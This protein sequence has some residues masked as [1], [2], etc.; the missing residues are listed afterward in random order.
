MFVY[1][2]SQRRVDESTPQN[3]YTYTQLPQ[4]PL[5]IFL[6]ICQ[7]RLAPYLSQRVTLRNGVKQWQIQIAKL[8][9]EMI[10][11]QY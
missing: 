6:S 7:M 8:V 10:V 4:F 11:I 3:Y 9:W 2:I 1:E 5:N